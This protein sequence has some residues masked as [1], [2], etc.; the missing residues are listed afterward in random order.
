VQGSVRKIEVL[1]SGCPRC[2]ETYRVVRQVV[3]EAGL[4]CEVAKVESYQRMAQLGVMA[5]PVVVVDG[6]VA[7]AGR[8]PKPEEIRELLGI[9]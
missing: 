5:T 6:G 8:V 2:A 4:A 7:I 3:D 1:G 9:G